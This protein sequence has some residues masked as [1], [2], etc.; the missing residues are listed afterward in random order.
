MEKMEI[1]KGC[2][3][4]GV[5]QG[6]LRV[7]REGDVARKKQK[8]LEEGEEG[9]RQVFIPRWR[10]IRPIVLISLGQPIRRGATM[11]SLGETHVTRNRPIAWTKVLEELWRTVATSPNSQGQAISPSSNLLCA[12]GARQCISGRSS[13]PCMKS[14][15]PGIKDNRTIIP[16]IMHTEEEEAV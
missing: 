5:D 13:T 2:E 9:G 4:Q 16:Y 6:E 7:A 11:S 8:G 3:A 12:H 14:H 1:G 10:L 15:R